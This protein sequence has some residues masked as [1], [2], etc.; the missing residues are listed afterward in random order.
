LSIFRSL[1]RIS[2]AWHELIS[3]HRDAFNDQR[4]LLSEVEVTTILDL[5]ANIGDTTLQYSNLF[6]K[7][8][9]YSFEP[10]PDLFQKLQARFQKNNLVK[11]I[12]AAVAD[13]SSD[14]NFYITR[15]NAAHS[16]LKPADSA[17]KWMYP[18]A[19]KNAIE[20][21][22]QIK[23]PV[24]TI[25][26][27]CKH[28]SIDKIHILKMDIQGGELMALGGAK[29]KLRKGSILLIYT[30]MFFV[31]VYEGQAYYNNICDFLSEYGF[32]LFDI[33]NRIYAKNG[34]LKWCDAIFIGPKINPNISP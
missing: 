1:R 7:A 19:D 11:P 27:F 31:P 18:H 23:V 3:G 4:N 25:D 8:K 34:Q 16:L 33:Y 17:E 21:L 30:E 32:S 22:E 12:K 14:R 15:H 2:D 20:I 10:F 9:I 24:L 5:G 29:E 6:T 26:D 28:E 13:T